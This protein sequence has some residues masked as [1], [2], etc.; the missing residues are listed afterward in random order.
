MQRK[1][2]VASAMLT[3]GKQTSTRNNVKFCT[4]LKH[5]HCAAATTTSVL[6]SA[7]TA[8]LQGSRLAC[9]QF[10]AVASSFGALSLQ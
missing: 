1:A 6:S 4:A 8:V 3:S 5:V 9:I 7:E 10:L 2:A